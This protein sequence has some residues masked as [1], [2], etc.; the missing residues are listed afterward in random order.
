LTKNEFPIF[1]IHKIIMLHTT[2]IVLL[3]IST[4]PTNI[5]AGAPK[6]ADDQLI[7][8][9]IRDVHRLARTCEYLTL[10]VL[11]ELMSPEKEDGMGDGDI[12]TPTADLNT[13]INSL[14]Q[15]Q[16]YADVLRNFLENKKTSEL[17]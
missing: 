9:Y 2:I 10:N 1:L 16:V 4:I 17:F 6:S 3:L 13:A 15:I 5:L 12:N 11:A 7:A 14:E 8:H